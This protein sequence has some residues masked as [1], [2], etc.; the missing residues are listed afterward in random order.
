MQTELLLAYDKTDDIKELF[1]E[2]MDMLVSNDPHFAYYLKLQ[3]YDD[4]LRDLT[5]K[6]G[7]PHGRLYVLYA[8]GAVAGCIG[9]RKLDETSCEMKRLYIKPRF[10]RQGFARM[11]AEKIIADAREIGYKYM[12]LDTL[13]FLKEAIALYFDLG[14]Y[15][16]DRYNDSPMAN[17]VYM[18]KDL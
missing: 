16:I 4:E 10:R 8:D 3:N 11:L 9:F 12:Y 1:S 7:L 2:Y 17:S 13:P 15:E 18:K 5:H 14:F 6:Y